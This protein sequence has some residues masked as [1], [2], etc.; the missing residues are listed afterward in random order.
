MITLTK[1][2]SENAKLG[3]NVRATYRKVG[4]TC[5][6]DCDL[7]ETGICY[8]LQGPVAIHAE[9][10]PPSHEDADRLLQYLQSLPGGK[11][12]R[13]H[14]SGDLFRNDEPDIPYV[15]SLL[16]GHANRPDVEGWMYTHGWKRLSAHV[17]NLPESL[18]V[19]ASCDT[20][21]EAQKAVHRGWPTTVVLQEEVD[22]LSDGTPIVICPN[23]TDG[24]TCSECGL[25]MQ[26]QRKSVVGFLE[27]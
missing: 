11:K 17:L 9:K 14:V 20:L 13:H 16:V 19:N 6:S 10:S 15:W 2:D 1:R 3:S 23:Q 22:E 26:G 21:E 7:L 5:P 24:V 4:E 12:I 27:H 8:A 25:C 18:T